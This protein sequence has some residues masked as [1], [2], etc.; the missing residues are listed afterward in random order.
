[1][2]YHYIAIRIPNASKFSLYKLKNTA[3][4]YISIITKAALIQ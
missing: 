1:M 2:T 4:P 3:T